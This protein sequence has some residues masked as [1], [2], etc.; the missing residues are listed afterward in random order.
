[1]FRARQHPEFAK[2][3]RSL[4]DGSTRIRPATRLRKAML[5]G[6]DKIDQNAD[7]ARAIRLAANLED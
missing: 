5:G 2:W 1:M 7:I 3:M 6:G 4:K